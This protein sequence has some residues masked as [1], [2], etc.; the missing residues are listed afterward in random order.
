MVKRKKTMPGW[1]L[2]FVGLPGAGKSTYARAV[3]E[4]LKK[5]KVSVVYLCMDDRRKLYFPEPEYTEKER[6]RAYMYFAEDAARM[7]Q[8]GQNVIMDGTAH[9]LSMREYMRHLVP[10]FAEILVRCPLDIAIE[11]E[12]N[13]TEG[14]T[15]ADLYKKALHRKETSAYYE[16]LGEVIGIDTE[17]EEN[18][19]A[20]CVIESDK[21]SVEQGRDKVLALLA[22]WQLVATR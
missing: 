18:P 17:F 15:R 19:S 11:R 5:E 7:A 10:R 8:G 3:C 20:E 6:A 21:E 13:R 9:R 2:W 1:V 22:R 14:G 4:E 12:S 16:G